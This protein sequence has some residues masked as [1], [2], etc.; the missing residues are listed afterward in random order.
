M[1]KEKVGPESFGYAN[2]WGLAGLGSNLVQQKQYAEAEPIVRESLAILQ[3]NFPGWD[4]FR[5][6]SL[7]GA[8]LLGQQKYA[9]AE[10]PLV[11]GYQGLKK[12]EQSH[13]HTSHGS[14]DGQNLTEAL[15]RLVQLYDAWA[16]PDEAAKWR[17]ELEKTKGKP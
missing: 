16:R 15:E 7:L 5:A 2:F 3:K 11:Q 4:S 1:L 9:D 12:L 14:L 13:G 8:V 10:P 6:E 17:K